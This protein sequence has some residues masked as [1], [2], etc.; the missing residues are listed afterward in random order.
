MSCENKQ[1][2]DFFFPGCECILVEILALE[3]SF[4]IYMDLGGKFSN[5][6]NGK[7]NSYTML[8]DAI[9]MYKSTSL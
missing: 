8:K 1:N 7:T 4:F 9:F 3:I 2:E 5:S 6:S